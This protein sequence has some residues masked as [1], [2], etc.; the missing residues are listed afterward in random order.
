MLH[1]GKNET[2]RNYSKCYWELYNTIE[3][4]SKEFAVV[5]YKLKLTPSE[6]LWDDL[7]LNPL[8][9]LSDP[10]SR[11]E[12]F[13]QLEDD[14]RQSERAMS[15]FSRASAAYNA[16]ATLSSH[17]LVVAILWLVTLTTAAGMPDAVTAGCNLHWDAADVGCSLL[18]DITTTVI[19][20][21][22]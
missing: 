4:F 8:I 13:S 5:N 1:K 7:T 17:Y 22:S 9:N 11:V 6:K 15:S 14:I 20:I 12:M 21:E 19:A 18:Y 3:E 16:T 10:M 2:F